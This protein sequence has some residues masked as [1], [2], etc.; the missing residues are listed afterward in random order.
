MSDQQDKSRPPFE[1]PESNTLRLF[2]KLIDRVEKAEPRVAGIEQS[3]LTL[4]KLAQS[5][6]ER[7]S[8]QMD[9]INQLGTAQ[10]NAD[11]R[12][13]ALADAQIRTED[14]LTRL[15]TAQAHT[16]RRLDAL[17]DTVQGGRNGQ[18][19]S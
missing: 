6:D 15:A 10:A 4:V 19:P 1:S 11:V 7:L 9:W 5:A 14:S 2:E 3:F 16:D 8:T 13:A 17:I 12:I 18:S